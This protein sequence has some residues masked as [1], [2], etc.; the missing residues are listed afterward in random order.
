MNYTLA[1]QLK[2]LGYYQEDQYGNPITLS[3][4]NTQKLWLNL[5]C[6]SYDPTLIEQIESS[7]DIAIKKLYKKHLLEINKK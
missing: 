5:R 4:E 3:N 6:D 1:K 2:D 7:R